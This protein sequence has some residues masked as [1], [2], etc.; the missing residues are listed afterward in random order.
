MSCWLHARSNEI[1]GSALQRGSTTLGCSIFTTVINIQP[2]WAPGSA[3]PTVKEV[4]QYLINDV[5]LLFLRK[6]PA[7]RNRDGL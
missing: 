1:V 3:E 2:V 7:L 6:V 4:N 5:G